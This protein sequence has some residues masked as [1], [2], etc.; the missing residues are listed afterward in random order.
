MPRVG[1]DRPVRLGAARAIL[2]LGLE[3]REIVDLQT[4]MA[5]LEAKVESL[6]AQEPAGHKRW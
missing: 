5:E 2:E 4:Q 3:F 1:Q 6:N